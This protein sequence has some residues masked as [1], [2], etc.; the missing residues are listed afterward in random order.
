[1]LIN[2]KMNN[3]NQNIQNIQ[4]NKYRSMPWKPNNHKQNLCNN[5]NNKTEKPGLE[6]E[7]D[8]T[9]PNISQP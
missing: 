2:N 3:T 4:K 8:V 1:M 9:M 5:N 6:K 7:K